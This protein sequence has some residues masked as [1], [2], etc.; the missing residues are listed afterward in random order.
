M[1]KKTMVLWLA[2]SLFVI[3]V[4]MRWA[5]SYTHPLHTLGMINGR[6]AECPNYPNC[7]SSQDKDSEHSID[8]IPYTLSAKET[9]RQLESIIQAMPRSRIVSS[10]TGY[11]HAEFSSLLL[12]FVDDVELAIDAKENLIHFRS[13][14]RLGRSDF[15]VNRR[16]M[17]QIRQQFQQH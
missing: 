16:R 7:V 11:V 4:G 2:A 17:E 8:S 1:A 3:L 6:L 14:A 15:G 9:Q 5:N 13:A 10:Q 12:G